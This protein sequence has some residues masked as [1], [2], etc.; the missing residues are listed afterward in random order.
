MIKHY[1]NTYCELLLRQKGS[2]FVLDSDCETSR[3]TSFTRLTLRQTSLL[4]TRL[5]TQPES[6]KLNILQKYP[7][8][9]LVLATSLRHA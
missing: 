5:Q 1:I 3:P 2:E 9:Y 6:Y 7:I 4:S 8:R